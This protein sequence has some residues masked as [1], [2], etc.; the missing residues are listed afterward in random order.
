MPFSRNGLEQACVSE[1]FLKKIPRPQ[2]VKNQGG[3]HST[4]NF[5]T[6]TD[7]SEIAW[8][9]LQEIRN[10]PTIAELQ[11]GKSNGNFNPGGETSQGLSFFPRIPF[12]TGISGNSNQNLV[13]LKHDVLIDNLLISG[14]CQKRTH[15]T[16]PS[17]SYR[18]LS[19]NLNLNF[20]Y[21]LVSFLPVLTSSNLFKESNMLTLEENIFCHCTGQQQ[22]LPPLGKFY[23]TNYMYF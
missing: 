8:E 16:F 12:D 17:N 18:R 20:S 21:C 1:I 9:N 3:L 2:T 10:L 14:V 5:L 11:V 22:L 23:Q 15:K 6:G 4:V 13:R 7:S 19:S